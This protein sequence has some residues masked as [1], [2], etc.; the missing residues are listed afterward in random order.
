VIKKYFN[1]HLVI[2]QLLLVAT[3]TYYNINL[4]YNYLWRIKQKSSY[5]LLQS[6]QKFQDNSIPNIPKDVFM[7]LGKKDQK[8]YVI[9]REKMELLE[10]LK[11]LR[12]CSFTFFRF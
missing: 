5:G 11:S 12:Q 1:N 9:P 7:A 2:S 6:Q 10:W 4:A 3:I 8:I